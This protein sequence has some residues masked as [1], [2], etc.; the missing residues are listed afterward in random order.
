M[1]RWQRLSFDKAVHA[2]GSPLAEGEVGEGG[3]GEGSRE[4]A[5][6]ALIRAVADP[7]REAV[8]LASL[9]DGVLGRLRKDLV[10]AADAVDSVGG[11]CGGESSAAAG[12][13]AGAGTGGGTPQGHV[14]AVLTATV[15]ASHLDYTTSFRRLAAVPAAADAAAAAVTLDTVAVA[16]AW[17]PAADAL[18]QSAFGTYDLGLAAAVAAAAPSMDSTEVRA[19]HAA[20][21]RMQPAVRRL[22][23]DAKLGR[24]G[25]SGTCTTRTLWGW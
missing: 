7:G 23:I 16:A 12:A 1:A 4:A 10:A 20:L 15:R 14:K 9:S 8:W 22:A 5:L 19:W 6:T 24:C 17:D 3:G 21:W 2:A 11:V 13:G 25:R 18:Y